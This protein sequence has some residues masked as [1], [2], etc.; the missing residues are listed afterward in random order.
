MEIEKSPDLTRICGE[1]TGD[2]HI[3]L[4]GWRRIVSFY[5]KNLAT[6]KDFE[7]RFSKIFRVKGRIYI[8]DRKWRSYRVFFI[9]R[10]VAEKLVSIGLL[11]G[12]K[13]NTPFL[14]PDWIINGESEIRSAYLAGLFTTEGSVYHTK[15]S[16]RWRIEMEMYKWEK[17]KT[18][19]VRFMD[20]IAGM[21]RSLG[22]PCSPVR[23]GRKDHRK[24]GTTS[25]AM[26]IDI[27]KGGFTNFY[28]QIGFFDKTKAER[29]LRAIGNA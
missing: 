22:V 9:S 16:D 23:I 4:K 19:G 7:V 26:K 13:T 14:V 17:Y 5:S 15:G 27:K 28:K 12:N 29:C 1:L 21:L 3:Q 24:D 11:A 20:Q 25:I 18:E 10:E 2:G 8:D 6:I